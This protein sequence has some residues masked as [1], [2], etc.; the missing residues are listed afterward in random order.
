MIVAA[1]SPVTIG[2]LVVAILIVILLLSALRSSINIVQ[3]GQVGVVKRLGEYQRTH[4]AGLVLILPFV[5]NLLAVP[6]RATA[7]TSSPRTTWSSP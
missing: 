2:S 6:C 5:D 7:R 1:M 4:E 3:Q